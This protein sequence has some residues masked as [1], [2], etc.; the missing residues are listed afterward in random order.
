LA[1]LRVYLLARVYLTTSVTS[2]KYVKNIFNFI[3]PK[4]FVVTIVK[5]N[6]TNYLL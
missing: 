6:G 2:S 5:L 3:V 4:H 1:L